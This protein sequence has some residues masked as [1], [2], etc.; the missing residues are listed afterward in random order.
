M[1]DVPLFCIVNN[2][3]QAGFIMATPPIIAACID[4]RSLSQ[5]QTDALVASGIR[6]EETYL[7]KRKKEKCG[8]CE[9]E[10]GDV[11]LVRWYGV[12]RQVVHESC[13][14]TMEP[15]ESALVKHIEDLY[16][17]LEETSRAWF[18]HET[19]QAVLDS[20]RNEYRV[21]IMA[22]VEKNG[23]DALTNLFNSHGFKAADS[24]ASQLRDQYPMVWKV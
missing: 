13:H 11:A 12:E 6:L 7:E 2:F 19:Y 10:N 3:T 17:R 21:S 1:I 14:K 18:M 9:K 22:F 8:L 15:I 16:L 4:M 24:C 20:I 23:A 5:E